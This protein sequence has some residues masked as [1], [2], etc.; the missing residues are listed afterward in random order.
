LAARA[1]PSDKIQRVGVLPAGCRRGACNNP[2]NTK[3][4]LGGCP[5]FTK[6]HR[7]STRSH[8]IGNVINHVKPDPVDQGHVL[9]RRQARMIQR[10]AS[11]VAGCLTLQQLDPLVRLGLASQ[12]SAGPQLAF[13]TC[14]L[15]LDI[16]I[17]TES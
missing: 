10:V 2:I 4:N 5:T 1:Q 9:S 12:N 3:E 17:I 6:P 14:R 13:A 8:I 7:A 15:R 11:I 16:S